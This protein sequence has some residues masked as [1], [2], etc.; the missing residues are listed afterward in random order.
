MGDGW[1]P[2]FCTPE[3]AVAGRAVVE[4]AAAAANRVID[5]EHFGALVTYARDAVPE[6]YA[7]DRFRRLGVEA[8][9]VVPVGFDALRARLEEFVAVGFTKLVVAP[10]QPV[11]SWD[12]E[13]DDVAAAVLDLQTR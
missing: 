4:Q 6:S 8:A 1:L 11:A 12:R 9:A 5:P 7:R 10:A 2:S 13:L 3:H